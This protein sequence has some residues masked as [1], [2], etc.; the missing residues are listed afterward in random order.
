MLEQPG[1]GLGPGCV[2]AKSA[3]SHHAVAG[4]D[5]KQ[6]IAANGPA[7]RAGRGRDP[8]LA[9]LSRNLGVGACVSVGDPSHRLPDVLLEMRPFRG[10]VKASGGGVLASEI[11]FEPGCGRRQCDRILACH[12]ARFS[13]RASPGGQDLQGRGHGLVN[14]DGTSEEALPACPDTDERAAARRQRQVP[15]GGVVHGECQ[16]R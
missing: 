11:L 13:P 6:G 15:D 1:F 12:T 9:Q 14:A 8:G 5:D 2:A 16:V 7:D 4:A 3:S 10:Y